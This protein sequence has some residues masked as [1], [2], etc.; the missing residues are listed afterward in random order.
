MKHIYKAKSFIL[1]ESGEEA[2]RSLKCLWR[3]IYIFDAPSV[4][5][6][7]HRKRS[8]NKLNNFKKW[9]FSAVYARNLE[10]DSPGKY[11]LGITT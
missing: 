5:T 1:C 7:C 3:K 6:H 11:W 4:K 2:V 9:N 10:F 8:Y